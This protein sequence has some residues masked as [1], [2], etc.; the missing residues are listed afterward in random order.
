M[1]EGTRQRLLS[2]AAELFSASPGEDIPLRAICERAGVKPPTLYHYFGSKEGV[3]NAVV[4][5][6]F[7]AYLRE[8][9][10]QES[11]GDPI[12]DIRSGW[13]THVAFGRSNPAFYALMYGRVSPG[14][15]SG[16]AERSYSLLLDLVT[17]ADAR[18]QLRVPPRQAA[19]HILATNVGVTLYLISSATP[20][21]S[22]SAAVRDATLDAVSTAARPSMVQD[23]IASHAGSLAAALATS[24]SEVPLAPEELA[25]LRRWLLTL[26]RDS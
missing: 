7:D 8:K 23:P 4:E 3:V 15:Q 22:L 16:P 18:G 17:R 13:D 25:L 5:Y 2:A 6:G 21:E 26:A 24:S 10:A 20:D 9:Q 19:H 12:E 14:Y 11:T 1:A